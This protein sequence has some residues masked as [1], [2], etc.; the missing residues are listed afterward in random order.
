MKVFA[1]MFVASAGFLLA[2]TA[3]GQA[4]PAP[5]P[6]PAAESTAKEQQQRAVSQPG[7]NQPVWTDVRSGQPGYTSIPGREAGVLV[8]GQARFFGQERFSTAGEAWRQ[9]RNG[10]ITFYG[11]WLVVLVAL[12]IAALNFGRG[13]IKLHDKPTGRLIERFSSA[14]RWA[15]WTM[16]ISFVVLGITGL[17]ILF[18]KY[19]LLPVI[20]YTLFA[21]L[22]ALAKNLHNFVAP[23]FMVSLLV[24]IFMFV[25]DNLP[26]AYDFSWFFKVWGLFFRG[27]HIPSGRFNAGEK[28]WFW[29]GVVVLCLIVSVS[30]LVMLFPNFEQLRSTMQQM[31]IIHGVAAL[32]VIAASLGHIYMGTIGVEGAYQSMR[33]GYVDEIW[34]KEHHQYWYDEVKSGASGSKPASASDGATAP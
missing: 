9:Y 29:G 21:W 10:P 17:I 22:T 3:W 26:K 8:Q 4:A 25:K 20:G 2:A 34:A 16:G 5:K 33:T 23:L 28:A 30:G 32:L 27:E 14:E 19:V 7:N 13:P 31:N 6:A 12:V 24:F 11:G 15:H 18:G 1:R